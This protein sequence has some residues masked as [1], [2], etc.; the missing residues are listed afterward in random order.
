MKEV[1]SC[2]ILLFRKNPHKQFLIMEHASRWDLPKGHVDPGETKRECA[3]RE[4]TEETG[5]AAESIKLIKGFRFER[6]YKVTN[7]KERGKDVQKRLV[8]YMAKLKKGRKA[9]V[10]VTEHIGYRWVDWS[11]PH[12]LQEKTINPLLAEAEKFFDEKS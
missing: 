11:P 5:I 4:F 6:T 1:M 9:K 8:I 7:W 2:G 3:L 12:D 10:K